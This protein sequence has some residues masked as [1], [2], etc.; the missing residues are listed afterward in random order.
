VDASGK[1][2]LK[3]VCD[4]VHLNPA[5]A[6]LVGLEE[7]LRSFTSTKRRGQFLLLTCSSPAVARAK[8]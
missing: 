3:S 4:Y 5:R 2:Y 6:R 8:K 7:A 1:G